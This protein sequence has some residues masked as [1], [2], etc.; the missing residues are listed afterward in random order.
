M[1]FVRICAVKDIREG[2]SKG[3]HVGGLEIALYH[4][5]AG[6]YATGNVGSHEHEHL[7][8]GWLE[9]AVIE[10][11]RH[12]AQFDVKTGEALSL[13][14]TEPIPVYPVEMRGDDVFVD[15]PG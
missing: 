3:F 11:P 15:I 10:C 8:E 12:G 6:W 5:D 2:N 14:A 9:G 13:P 7:A 1:P 4:T